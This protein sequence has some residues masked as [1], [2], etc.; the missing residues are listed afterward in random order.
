MALWGSANVKGPSCWRCP[1]VARWGSVPALLFPSLLL[2]FLLVLFSAVSAQAPLTIEWQAGRLSVSAEGVPLAQVLREV[3]RWTGIEVEGLEGLQEPVSVRF[4]DLPLREALEKLLAQRDYAILG[5]LSLPKGKP[6]V[7]VV[8]PGRRAPSAAAPRDEGTDPE[9]EAALDQDPEEQIAA[10]DEPL[11][12]APDESSLRIAAESGQPEV[13]ATALELLGHLGTPS[14]QMKVIASSHSE[15][16]E[17]RIPALKV[18]TTV[19]SGEAL[20]ALT[21][22][23]SED[24]QTVKGAAIELLVGMGDPEAFRLLDRAFG[25]SDAATRLIMIQLL[26]Q[27]GGEESLAL[28]RKGVSDEDEVIRTV[29]QELLEQYEK[30]E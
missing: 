10:L 26:A 5:D 14:A 9:G 22:A 20:P 12:M 13:R 27:R 6:P 24:D 17:E 23:L 2:A 4:G 19:D 7:L 18:L 8:G 16:P 1:S 28:L 3:A 25:D 11:D 15:N 21:Q 30:R 29:A